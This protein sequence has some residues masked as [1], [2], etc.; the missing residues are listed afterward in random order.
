MDTMAEAAEA[1]SSPRDR[2][3][4]TMEDYFMTLLPL[5]QHQEY[6]LMEQYLKACEY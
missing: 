2:M 5:A 4:M 6:F 1:A 3:E